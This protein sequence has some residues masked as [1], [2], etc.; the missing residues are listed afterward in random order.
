MQMCFFANVGMQCC[1]YGVRILQSQYEAI[2]RPIA[3]TTWRAAVTAALANT[4]FTIILSAPLRITQ[5]APSNLGKPPQGT[6]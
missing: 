5:I 6:I 3:F 1:T 2:I 4:L